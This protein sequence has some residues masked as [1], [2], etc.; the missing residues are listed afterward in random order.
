MSDPQVRLEGARELRAAFKRLG[1]DLGDLADLHQEIG[2]LV[3]DEARSRIRSRTGTLAGSAR[4]S[5]AKTSVVIRFGGARVPY[6]NAIHWGTGARPG[7]RGPHNIAPNRFATD[8]AAATEP[9]WTGMYLAKVEE[10]VDR[11]IGRSRNSA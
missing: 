9:T 4:A 10:L 3:V 6:A 7:Q 2:N 11:A 5:R 8:A 1:D